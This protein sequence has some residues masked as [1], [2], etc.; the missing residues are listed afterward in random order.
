MNCATR[1]EQESTN[2]GVRIPYYGRRRRLQHF[3]SNSLKDKDGCTALDVVGR[4]LA[5]KLKSRR[6]LD[7]LMSLHQGKGALNSTQEVK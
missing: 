1:R 2:I 4:T 7:V 6:M 5:L 3:P